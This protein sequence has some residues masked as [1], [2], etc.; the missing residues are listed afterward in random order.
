MLSRT[1]NKGEEIRISFKGEESCSDPL[2]HA[3][4]LSVAL[5][6]ATVVGGPPSPP[7]RGHLPP[8]L[9]GCSG[10]LPPRWQSGQRGKPYLANNMLIIM[11][12]FSKSSL[13]ILLRSLHLFLLPSPHSTPLG[14][15]RLHT[16]THTYS[17]PKCSKRRCT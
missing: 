17:S 15:S 5:A 10:S 1:F 6:E 16:H 2:Q 7:V 9:S 3:L 4:G 14:L 8:Q 12:F 13:F 11:L